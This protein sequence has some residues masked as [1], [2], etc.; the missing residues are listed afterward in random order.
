MIVS[1]VVGGQSVSTLMGARAQG[2][3]YSSNALFDTWGV[4]NNIAGIARINETTA[5]FSFDA[6]TALPG[7]NRTAA[8]V[9]WPTR[10]GVLGGGV[11][12]FGDDLYSESILTAGFSNQMGIASLGLRINYIQYRAEGFG[13]KGVFSI[14][15]GGIAELT[16]RLFV[17]AHITNLN[18]PKLSEDGDRLPTLLTM[19]VAFKPTEKVF[20]ATDLEKD[21][22]YKPTW[23]LGGEYQFHKKFSARTGFNVN[24]NASFFGLGFKTNKFNLDYS[25]QYSSVLQFSHQASVTYQFSKT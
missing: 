22:D 18:Q 24:P 19:G 16:P 7:G 2:I 4:F 12:Q 11:F 13:S 25:L 6:R 15:F 20:I 17:G 3:G 9:A 1:F 23:K 14:N 10:L 21:L 5:A 8:V